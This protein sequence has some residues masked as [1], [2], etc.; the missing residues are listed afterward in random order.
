VAL[1]EEDA[2]DDAFDRLVERC[3][4]EDD[5][6]QPLPPSSSVS[7][8]FVPA[9]P[10]VSILPTAVEPVNAILLTSP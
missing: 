10:C 9:T 3:V 7:F 1:V 5:V 8:F 6:A 4:F 2:G